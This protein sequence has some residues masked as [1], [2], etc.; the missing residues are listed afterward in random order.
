MAVLS[1]KEP[2]SVIGAIVAGGKSRRMGTDKTQ[3]KIGGRDL[4]EHAK[5]ILSKAK[6][7]TVFISHPDHIPDRISDC[8]PL[9]GIDAILNASKE[10]CSHVIFIP[11]D[12]PMMKPDL[13]S[14]LK[15][16]N[17][18][19]IA[20][21]FSQFTFPFR[22]A[23]T[24]FVR[25]AVKERLDQRRQL[26]LM[27]LQSELNCLEVEIPETQNIAFANLN[28]PED[29]ERFSLSDGLE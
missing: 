15:R 22:L 10:T 13:L 9:G 7:E 29:W 16:S 19:N 12:M 3:L 5:H 28:S 11:V 23:N 27:A 2:N 25:K 8:G 24:A 4:L 14:L 1:P 17:P 26:S 6:I 18:E 20:V 21:R